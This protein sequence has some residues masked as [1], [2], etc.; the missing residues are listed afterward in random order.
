MVKIFLQVPFN[1]QLLGLGKDLRMDLHKRR[2]VVRQI[3]ELR[4]AMLKESMK[5]NRNVNSKQVLAII[6]RDKLSSS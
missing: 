4:R 6:N 2:A 3:E 5:R 1:L